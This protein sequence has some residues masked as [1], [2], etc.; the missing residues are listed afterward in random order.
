M[1]RVKAESQA[2]GLG[3]LDKVQG[4]S[5]LRGW[6]RVTTNEVKRKTL[7]EHPRSA[8]RGADTNTGWLTINGA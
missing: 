5:W 4:G 7:N 8:S 3:L 1:K 2:A 6:P